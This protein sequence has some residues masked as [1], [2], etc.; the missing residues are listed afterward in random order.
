MV[1]RLDPGQVRTLRAV[2][3]QLL[4]PDVRHPGSGEATALE[5]ESLL[6]VPCFGA[7]LAQSL[8]LRRARPSGIV[9]LKG[10]VCRPKTP[11][12]TARD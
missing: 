3:Q 7:C 4:R 1:V 6:A 12:A 9:S 10:Y 5:P 2:A 8:S 11:E